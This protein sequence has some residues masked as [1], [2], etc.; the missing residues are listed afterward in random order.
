MEFGLIGPLTVRCDGA[1]VPVAPGKQRAV[2]AALLLDAGRVVPVDELAEALWGPEPP[3]S[4]R[5]TV[6][7]YVMRLRKALGVAGRDLITTQPGGYL[8]SVLPGE[9]DVARFAALVC[10]ARSAARAGEWDAAAAG[11]RAA[12]AL[13]RGEPLSDVGSEALA[14]REVPRLA[15]LRLQALE[16]R[17]EA[18][19]RAGRQAEVIAEA[20]AL[21]AEHPLR[22]RL[23]AL[24]MLAL[25]RDGRSGE[26]LAAYQQARRVLVTELGAEPGAALR[27]LHQQI[28][29]ADPALA[30]S[31]PA[32][33]A[34]GS[35]EPGP[36]LG[37]PG[38]GPGGGRPGGGGTGP[39]VPRQL[40]GAV[41]HFAGRAAELAA[42][43]ALLDQGGER[44]AETIVISAISGT[45]GVGKTALAVRWAHQVADRFPDGQ[46][47]V[48][49]RGYDPDQPV[50]A[51]DALAGFLSAL[52]V[53]G[54]DIPAGADERAG[55]YRSLLAG[56][57][58]LVVLDNARE[59]EQVRL[60][61]PG[62]SDC[63][64]VVTSRDSLAGLVARHG[65]SRLEVGL[66]PIADAVGLLRA[67]IGARADAD[68]A[69]AAALAARCARL[70]LALR[71]AAELAAALPASSLEDLVCEL[72]GQQRLDR[73]DAGGDPR[74]AVRT[75]FSWS[76]R[77]L[78]ADAARAFR[79]LGLHPGPGFD[80]YAAAAMTGSTAETAARLL[81]QLA[82]AHLIH[83]TEPGRYG[84]HDLLREYAAEQAAAEEPGPALTR[85]FDHYLH[86]ASAAM[87][88]L[89]PAE[90]HR[91]PRVAAPGSP[92]PAVADPGAA[93]AWLDAE[94]AV[95]VAVAAHTAAHGWPGHTTRLAAT[96]WR[97]LD[98]G[99]HYPD[100]I[101]LHTHARIAA[102]RAGDRGAEAAALT[103][104]GIA[105]WRQGRHEQAAGLHRQALALFRAAGDRPGEARALGNLGLVEERRGRHQRA[106]RH[107]GQALA[108]YRAAGD[109]P[110]EA[111]ALSNLGMVEHV[112]GRYREAAGHFQQA[113]DQ[114][115]AAGDRTG[116]TRALSNLGA[117]KE[118][119]GL[120]QEAVRDLERV[121]VM[122]RGTGDRVVAANALAN[123]GVVEERL[124]QYPQAAGHF[125]QALDLFRE[126]GDRAGQAESL[127]GLGETLLATG[128]HDQARARLAAALDLAAQAG[129]RQQQARA[130][131]G[132]GR[133]GQAAGDAAQARRHWQ[134]ALTRYAD[135]RAPEA[136]AVR[137]RLTGLA[138]PASAAGPAGPAGAG[139]GAGAAG[140]AGQATAPV[141]ASVADAV[142]AAGPAS[143]AGTASGAG[144]ATPAR[145]AIAAGRCHRT[146][147]RDR[148]RPRPAT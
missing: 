86:T 112:L 130:H 145:P 14:R 96:V 136:D 1:A 66:L 97:H 100:A 109:R 81:G 131:D 140:P 82:R 42:L 7:N 44:A 79:L 61:L 133:A 148:T 32:R 73:L 21:A 18:D 99:A 139:L 105:A 38:P 116:E 121:L 26:A 118:R 15:E 123:L 147:P 141:P 129:D 20:Q 113:L 34:P 135:L 28:L 40:P 62:A 59:V 54:P 4:A 144:P 72:A 55:R 33:P 114:F 71:V 120:Y 22:E 102:R 103:S 107:H 25:H 93:R 83:P 119:L 67:L 47:Y 13:W 132:L 92:V 19:L 43:T 88:A 17:I 27:E 77:Y 125:Q 91:R 9:V 76:C 115:R 5:V 48:N 98:T 87:D 52:G 8:I 78:D 46:L 90:Q 142:G 11:S 36:E 49:L 16:A 57:R 64:V 60:L 35:P 23:H 2:L 134:E 80:P 101:T 75:V 89:Y 10:A 127:N 31:R 138:G 12:L 94:R 108:L 68:P 124:G 39:V 85:L 6:Q 51:A 146:R 74:T 50:S 122:S 128:E 24:L 95:L 106:A 69:A 137:S 58:M 110:G 84:L 41:P 111:N 70:P 29:G 30:R 45:A 65:A 117:A 53:P 3:A 63:V 143:A 56:R 37:G 126:L 104:L